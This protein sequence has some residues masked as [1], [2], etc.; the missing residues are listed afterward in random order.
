MNFPAANSCIW[1]RTL[2][3][4]RPFRG[5]QGRKAIQRVPSGFWFPFPSRALYDPIKDLEP[6]LNIAVSA[7]TIA[8]HPSVPAHTL[9]E[10][11]DYAKAN[12]GKLSLGSTGVG[13]L[14]H[15]TVELRKSLAETPLISRTC[16][17]VG[18]ARIE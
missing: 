15:L 12:P 13:T 17:G 7:F 18:P 2:P 3:R 1:Q 8:V 11:V 16:Q 10:L 4:C 9:K 14:P 5:S 6:I